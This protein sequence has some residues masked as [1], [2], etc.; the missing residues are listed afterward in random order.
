[1][2]S[3]GFVAP[4]FI[5]AV[6]DPELRPHP[7]EARD[8]GWFAEDRLP[9]PLAGADRWREMAF[10]AVRGEDLPVYFDAPRPESWRGEVEA[11]PAE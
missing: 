2:V 4:D 7:L 8:V 6:P 1:M 11:A 10:A 9:S 5:A 3:P